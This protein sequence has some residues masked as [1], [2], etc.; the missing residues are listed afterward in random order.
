MIIIK[1]LIGII[2]ILA[3]AYVL[4]VIDKLTQRYVLCD[5][6]AADDAVLVL[7]AGILGI[8]MIA[9]IVWCSLWLIW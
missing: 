7:L 9:G 2:S 1:T 4:Y 8:A 5:E 3:I 6:D